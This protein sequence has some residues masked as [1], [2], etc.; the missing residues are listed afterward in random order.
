MRQTIDVLCAMAVALQLI[1]LLTGCQRL[2]GPDPRIA[3]AWD[4]CNALKRAAAQTCDVGKHLWDCEAYK[5][6][7]RECELI[8]TA[9]ENSP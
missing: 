9:A 5:R 1:Q 8:V 2:L 4:E 7:R 6:A 3:A